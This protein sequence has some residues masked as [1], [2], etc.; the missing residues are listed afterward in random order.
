MESEDKGKLAHAMQLLSEGK[1]TGS[2]PIFKDLIA[3]GSELPESFYG[4]GMIRLR[5]GQLE[6]ATKQFENCVKLQPN[7]ANALYY[8][9]QI[10]E[11][12][13]DAE[14]ANNFYQKAL[15][16]NPK[17]AGALKKVAPTAKPE[18]ARP[19]APPIQSDFYALLRA[20][21]E[22][23]EQEIS[24][25]L[26]AIAARIGTRHARFRAFI[27]LG[28][29]V[30]MILDAMA[31]LVLGFLLSHP[32]E[33]AKSELGRIMPQLQ[34][35]LACLLLLFPICFIVTLTLFL[36]TKYMEITC[37][38][39][40]LL[41]TKGVLSK[42]TENM[43]L[44]VLSRGQVSVSQT[45]MNRM[46]GDGT[47][48]IGGLSL[49]GYFRKPELADLSTHFR[50]LSLPKPTSRQILAAIGELKQIRSGAN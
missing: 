5:S 15:A 26:D 33:L 48:S 24:R 35:L 4:M 46:T 25:H 13:N 36:Q 27:S 44:F 3:S 23:V 12:R 9:G 8:L 19:E 39:D 41:L 42:S 21:A 37:E 14:G 18:K 34:L 16:I 6:N 22:P 38:R 45:F 31:C 7:H 30:L 50:Q 43:H 17:H 40:W 2:E 1:Y 29:V 11:Q 28:F 49:H 10:A 32:A 20:S 47:L